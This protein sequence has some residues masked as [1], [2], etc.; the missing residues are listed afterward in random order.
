MA[1][2]RWKHLLSNRKQKAVISCFLAV[3]FFKLRRYT[4][5]FSSLS[6]PL[7][8]P[9]SSPSPLSTPPSLPFL[10]PFPHHHHHHFLN[11]CKWL[12]LLS[13]SP[14]RHSAINLFLRVY[15]QEWLGNA[16]HST[17]QLLT[18]ELLDR[19]DYLAAKRIRDNDMKPRHEQ[20]QL[21][22]MEPHIDPLS[23]LFKMLQRLATTG[24]WWVGVGLG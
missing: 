14:F 1:K 16:E 4:Q 8:L 23:Q 2:K 12:Y 11:C 21:S 19:Q 17:H 22:Q 24:E 15:C 20:K 6:P 10:P 5:Y 7:P 18:E 3:P 13:L 9:P